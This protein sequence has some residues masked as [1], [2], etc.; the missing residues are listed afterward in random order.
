MKC[1][2]PGQSGMFAN[3][4]SMDTHNV[5]SEVTNSDILAAIQ[6]VQTDISSIKNSMANL[7]ARV[8]QHT[9]QIADIN[10]RTN[11]LEGDVQLIFDRVIDLE[12]M[13]FSKEDML[14]EVNERTTRL[15][16]VII[17]NF[18]ENPSLPPA[19]ARQADEKLI[20][21][22][23]TYIG[24]A[25]FLEFRTFFRIGK[26]V[27]AP[28]KPRPTK[29]VFE[30]QMQAAQF[31]KYFWDCKKDLVKFP[32]LKTISISR[33]RTP[34]QQQEYQAVRQKLDRLTAKGMTNWKIVYNGAIPILKRT[35]R[36]DDTTQPISTQSSTFTIR[37]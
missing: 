15:N 8:D 3:P 18:N 6:A 28:K 22:L 11:H 5:Q 34:L 17:H 24:V 35:S 2:G 20:A 7:T 23:F 27:P 37:T 26:P 1:C 9:E 19:E 25:V 30:N 4:E 12:N 33:D 29:I 14:R 32:Q 31:T 13:A 16:N 21:E 36:K 10:T